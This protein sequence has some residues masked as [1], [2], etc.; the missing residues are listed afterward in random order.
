MN[1]SCCCS[2]CLLSNIHWILSTIQKKNNKNN[3][4]N[5]FRFP[6]TKKFYSTH[7]FFFFFLVLVKCQYVIAIICIALLLPPPPLFHLQNKCVY[8]TKT[9]TTNINKQ[10]PSCTHLIC[11]SFL[12]F[13]SFIISVTNSSYSSSLLLKNELSFLEKTFFSISFSL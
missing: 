3:P 13:F 1:S 10:H 12:V 2:C 8:F 11:A 6:L 4:E 9:T 7:V 5:T